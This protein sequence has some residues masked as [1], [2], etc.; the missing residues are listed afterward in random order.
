[1]EQTFFKLDRIDSELSHGWNVFKGRDPT[2]DPYLSYG[3][4]APYRPDRVLLNIGVERTVLSAMY[5][6][7]AIDVSSN[8][9][10]HCRLNQNGNFQEEMKS[11]LN[12]CLNTQANIDQSGR[13]LIQD[14]ALSL[15]D[16][17]CVAIVPTDTDLD[18]GETGSWDILSLRVGQ[19]LEWFPKH[20]KVRVYN[21]LI[22]EKEDI[23]VP[24]NTVAIVE[25][26][27]Y[28]VMNEPNSIAKRLVHKLNTLDL[29]DDQ[30]TSGKLDL[31]IHLPYVIRTEQKRKE[32]DKRRKDIEMQLSGSK[33]GIA[34]IDGSERVTQLNRA[35]E[36]NVLS[37]VEYLTKMLYSQL[38]FTEGVFNGTATEEEMLNYYN[39]TVDPVLEAIT[40]AMIMAFLTKT[41]ITQKQS[42][43][44]FRN[45][46]KLVSATN[47]AEIADKLTRNE[48]LSS[49]EI[50][51][52]IGY[53]PS[54]DP[55]A[56]ELRNKNLKAS[57]DQLETPPTK[58]ETSTEEGE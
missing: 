15:F 9:I 37:E 23:V 38:G 13:A 10:V 28:A 31:L 56:D 3:Y 50:R 14:I 45:P 47:I 4:G 54:S 40:R 21:E 19:I 46:F 33:Y 5:N 12:Y 18:V 27:L 7:I 55:R 20:V 43:L 49:N 16:E 44:Y 58:E 26:P 25:N 42:I 8:K 57:N 30:I 17:G 52:I 1:M 24:K 34:Y 6:R 41:A 39:R 29:I 11:G 48:I 36:N 22:G 51:A 32:A 35:A 2:R 53:E